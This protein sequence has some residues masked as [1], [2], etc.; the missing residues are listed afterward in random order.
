MFRKGKTMG[1]DDFS[2]G[3]NNQN[4]KMN[5]VPHGVRKDQLD[6]KLHNIFNA[7]DINK[8]G[9]LE[10]EEL[11]GLESWVKGLAGIDGNGQTELVYGLTG[12]E[13][14]KNGKITLCGTVKDCLT[15]P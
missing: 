8:D 9:T 10:K 12:L 7:F 4:K 1:L 11:S 13:P 2:L 6:E 3:S 14:V 15:V 5:N